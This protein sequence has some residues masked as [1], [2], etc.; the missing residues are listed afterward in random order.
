M[1]KSSKSLIVEKTGK[2]TLETPGLYVALEKKEQL[3]GLSSLGLMIGRR[4]FRRQKIRHQ[5]IR[6]QKFR[7]ID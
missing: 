1:K 3:F 6:R 7:L 2:G 4:K 5:K